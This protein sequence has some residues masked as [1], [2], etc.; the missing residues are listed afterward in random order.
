MAE[1][2]AEKLAQRA[3]ELGLID[4]RQIEAIRSELEADATPEQ[5][6]SLLMRREYLTNFQLERLLKGDRTGFF[7]GNYK[8]LYLAGSGT[9]ARVYRGVHRET[10]KVFAVKVLRKRFRDDALQMELFLREGEVGLLLRHPNVVPTYEVNSDP[11]SPFITMDFVEGQNLREWVK[12]RK[13][14]DVATALQLI[15]DITAGLTY[16]AQHGIF[17]RDL[18]LSNVLVTSRGVA[19]LVDFGLFGTRAG[20]D[21]SSDIPN[22]RTIDYVALERA[23]G[24]RKN[25]PRSDIYFTGAMFYHLLVGE[26]PLAETRDRL[27]RLNVSRF[28]EMRPITE[29]DSSLPNSVVAVIQRAM[30]LNPDRRYQSPA[31]MLADL[32]STAKRLAAGQDVVPEAAEVAPQPRDESVTQHAHDQEGANRT[33]MIVESSVEMQNLLRERLKK[34]GYRV[35][36]FGDPVRAMA[37][38]ED[39]QPVADGVIFS[40]VDLKD[41]VIE[42]FNRFGSYANTKHLPAILFVDEDQAALAAKAKLASHHAVL[43]MPLK[44]R[45][46]RT[47][48]YRLLSHSKAGAEAEIPK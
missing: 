1:L 34:H 11:H 17:H 41:S 18:K 43:K 12:M 4:E 48:L 31:E 24:V 14:F 8:M 28:R 7:Y 9:F 6:R 21:S 39:D 32:Q 35:L 20:D 42:A 22:A 19:R 46:L 47:T 40:A 15:T 2:S 27:Q 26:S 16:A 3:Y 5:F 37:R 29:L 36:V 10:G 23:T 33:V 38:F 30:E 25:D 13:K 45:E 44:V